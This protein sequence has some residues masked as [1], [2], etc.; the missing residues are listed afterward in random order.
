[1]YY[2]AAQGLFPSWDV[3]EKLYAEA[4]PTPPERVWTRPDTADN[5]LG[6]WYVKTD[7][8]GASSGRLAGRRVAVKDNIGVAGVPMMNGSTTL[9][10][11]V[12]AADATVV[13][14]V[15]AA[16]ASVAGKAVCEDLCFSGGSLTSKPGPVRNPWDT[17]RASGGS[18]SGPAALVA[19]GQVDLAIG[20][21]QGGSIRIPSS[22]CGVVGHKPTYGLVPYTGGFPIELT[23]DHLGPITRTVEDAALLLSVLAGPDGKDPRQPPALSEVDY[24][25]SLREPATG[26]RIGV[27]AEGFGRPK[28]EPQVDRT[29]RGALD[30]FKAAGLVVEDVSIPWH[31]HA[32]AIWNVIAI[33]GATWQMVNGNGHGMNWKGRYD[34]DQI[35]FYGAKWRADPT[36]FS[37]TVK[38]L[39]MSGTY[40]ADSTHGRYYA[41]ARDLELRLAAAYDV[42][43]ANYDV[44]IMPT[45]PMRAT[46]LPAPGASVAEILSRA[47]E[48]V[49]NTCPFNVTGH[50]ACSVPAGLADGLPVGMMIV[51]RKF[52]DATVLRVARAFEA[53]VGGFPLPDQ[54]RNSA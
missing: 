46:E 50:P 18:S 33:E 36:A 28:S 48:M 43:F 24:V 32:T 49:G 45:T 10:G 27:V 21:D 16:G 38:L 5:P 31:L 40:A 1:M 19:A 42:E 8:G 4:A 12:P 20:G 17:A 25:A 52:Q 15:L 13:S 6:A 30:A 44:L 3:V 22:W 26:L 37:E 47:L 23:I 9:E 39:I 29:V 2:S 34:P 41:M 51:G 54:I 14:R 53:A 7:I 35:E 11:F